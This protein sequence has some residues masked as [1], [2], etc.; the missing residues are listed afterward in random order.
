MLDSSPLAMRR[1]YVFGEAYRAILP[2][3]VERP[4]DL[5]VRHGY[6]LSIGT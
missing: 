1:Q 2:E 6:V 3:Y 5:V 4:W